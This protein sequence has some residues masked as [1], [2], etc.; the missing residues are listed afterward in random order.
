MNHT[1]TQGDKIVHV[2]ALSFTRISDGVFG[3]E[4]VLPGI[5]YLLQ[6]D[7]KEEERA[8]NIVQVPN[9]EN[10]EPDLTSVKK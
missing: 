2:Q 4:G 6:K 9:S 5:S 10:S 8:L 3:A 7:Y 1:F